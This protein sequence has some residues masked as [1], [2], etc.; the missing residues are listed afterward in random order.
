[1]FSRLG[2]EWFDDY[3]MNY[4]QITITT[5]EGK[6]KKMTSLSEFVKYRGG[7]ANLIV[8]KA[9]RRKRKA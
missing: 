1:M 9:S 6:T 5:K 2:E 4:G 3:W 7:D 8:P